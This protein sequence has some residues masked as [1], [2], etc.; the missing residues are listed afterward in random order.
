MLARISHTDFAGRRG[1]GILPAAPAVVPA[2]L[3]DRTL[4]LGGDVETTLDTAGVDARATEGVDASATEGV[5][6]RAT[7]IPEV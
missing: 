2:F 6:A 1:V 7:G 5:D 4:L 3:D